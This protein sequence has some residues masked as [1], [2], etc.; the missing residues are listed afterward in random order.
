[1]EKKNGIQNLKICMASFKKNC[2]L[3]VKRVKEGYEF[4]FIAF[5]KIFIIIE[6]QGLE[7]CIFIT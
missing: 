5:L 2:E 6:I 7:L 4:F 3:L 1:L